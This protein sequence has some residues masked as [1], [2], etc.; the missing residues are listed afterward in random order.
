[1]ILLYELLKILVSSSYTEFFCSQT[2]SCTGFSR[3]TVVTYLATQ[4]DVLGSKNA[5]VYL[6]VERLSGTRNLMPVKG[7]N[8][9]ES[10][11]LREQWRN[12]VIKQS[13][14]SSILINALPAR[15]E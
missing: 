15:Y 4:I 5:Q 14:V 13:D 10:L 1:M 2:Y 3:L 8:V 6:L 11:P 7:I 9:S 12:K